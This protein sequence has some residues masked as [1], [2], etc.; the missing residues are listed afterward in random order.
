M[1]LVSTNDQILFIVTGKIFHL[2]LTY[3]SIPK[4][5]FWH[6]PNLRAPKS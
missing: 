5:N 4:N 3:I 6:K 1:I 2:S